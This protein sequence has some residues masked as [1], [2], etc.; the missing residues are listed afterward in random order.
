[1]THATL[2]TDETGTFEQHSNTGF[3]V[4]VVLPELSNADHAAIRDELRDH[5][6]CIF[7]GALGRTSHLKQFGYG[8]FANW[9]EIA[10]RKVG[11]ESNEEARNRLI[12]EATDRVPAL[13]AVRLAEAAKAR[14]FKPE[15]HVMAVPPADTLAHLQGPGGVLSASFAA[16][17]YMIST[18]ELCRQ[19]LWHSPLLNADG[20]PSELRLRLAHRVFAGTASSQLES[21]GYDESRKD[22]EGRPLYDIG[23][24]IAYRSHIQARLFN[25][26]VA[27]R[28]AV[29]AIETDD[30][31]ATD[32][33]RGM[34]A[35][36]FAFSLSR[37][38]KTK[39]TPGDLVALVPGL[40][41]WIVRFYTYGPA[42]FAL[43][44]AWESVQAGAAS[45]A[46]QIAF[47]VEQPRT[48]RPL[49]N[50]I[51][52]ALATNPDTRPEDVLV[53]CETW[54]EQRRY[55]RFERVRDLLNPLGAAKLST[56]G[57]FRLEYA[58]ISVHNHLGAPHEA[59]RL[60]ASN[61]PFADV[62][63]FGFEAP[64]LQA[65]IAA[66]SV[67]TLTDTFQFTEAR[68][69]ATNAAKTYADCVA[70]VAAAL[71]Q[72]IPTTFCDRHLGALL[73]SAAQA[74]AHG[75]PSGL[76]SATKLFTQAAPHFGDDHMQ[77]AF[78]AHLAIQAGTKEDA[79]HWAA[80]AL[81]SSHR[82]AGFDVAKGTALLGSER[83]ARE[84]VHARRLFNAYLL[85]RLAEAGWHD[86]SGTEQNQL[87]LLLLA[88]RT[89]SHPI[90]IVLDALARL[91]F[92]GG[93]TSQA[94]TLWA[95]CADKPLKPYQSTLR[96]LRGKS[97]A[98]LGLNAATEP[99]RDAAT[100]RLTG[101]LKS[102]SAAGAL[103]ALFSPVVRQLGDSTTRSDAC[104]AY[105]DRFH[106][107]WA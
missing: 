63:A 65:R 53:V 4:A 28:A 9:D 98:R 79:L 48:H 57:V 80:R 11:D 15:L 87:S 6:L 19:V 36:A 44:R 56:S 59:L 41:H 93:A 26:S 95:H 49:L 55:E 91:R 76:R 73:S 96:L 24:V 20:G 94:R 1:M 85:I 37:L 8:K 82:D 51:F 100:T 27:P 61:P 50:R 23:G 62:A 69:L 47:S 72:P 83:A 92:A 17:R 39:K 46:L 33:I 2:H 64:A 34:A 77:A 105:L 43:N 66:R 54:L 68:L 40:E 104:T 22:R 10:R 103:P 12:K 71:G 14:G 99:E 52:D 101:E 21:L 7:T 3:V 97:L 5:H 67:V 88:D 60:T 84:E 18:S 86:I 38:A 31:S 35:D 29:T 102:L 30:L 25:L 16:N 90:H 70:A 89:T 81:G 13:F 74:A 58:R 42:L 106:F 107:V 45:D 75:G 32:D 78:R